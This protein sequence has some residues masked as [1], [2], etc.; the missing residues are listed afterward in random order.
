VTLAQLSLLELEAQHRAAPNY[1][2]EYLVKKKYTD[3][4]ANGLTK[5]VVDF[6]NLS[7]HQA[8]RINTTGRYLDNSKIVTDV[9]G[10]Q[11]V[12]GKGKY[13][14]ST[15]T[16]GS[17]DIS[18]TI[19]GM[20]VKWEVKMKDKQSEYQKKYQ[21]DIERAGGKYFIIHNFEEFIK[22]YESL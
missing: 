12:L 17:A 10:M 9:T 5:C 22:Y 14:P 13:I 21:A 7:G 4:T 16:R 1:P 3:K 18:S 2:K 19:K 8:E 15:S 6:L 11:R 20:S